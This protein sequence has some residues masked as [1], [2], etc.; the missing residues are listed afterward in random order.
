MRAI[1]AARAEAASPAE[2][3]NEDCNNH[4]NAPA[5]SVSVAAKTRTAATSARTRTPLWAHR[6]G[7]RRTPI[8]VCLPPPGVRHGEPVNNCARPTVAPISP[9]C[10]LPASGAPAGPSSTSAPP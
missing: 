6:F 1:W 4:N 9:R 8:V 10:Q 3:C 2:D 7:D 5:A